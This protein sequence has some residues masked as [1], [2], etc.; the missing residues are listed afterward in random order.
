MF[1][2]DTGRTHI[3]GKQKGRKKKKQEK[4]ICHLSNQSFF[5]SFYQ[6]KL[7]GFFILKD[8]IFYEVSLKNLVPL[9]R[10]SFDI[11]HY[12]RTKEY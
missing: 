6:T 2:G 7:K 1:K 3:R 11:L 4:A 12:F 10:N 8:P 5:F 9:Q